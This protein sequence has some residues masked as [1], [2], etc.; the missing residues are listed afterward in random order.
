LNASDQLSLVGI[1]HQW[2]KPEVIKTRTGKIELVYRLVQTPAELTAMRD[3]LVK[4]THI[5]YDSE[6]SG[7]FVHLGARII[8]HALACYTG[9]TQITAWYIPIRHIGVDNEE[10]PQLPVELVSEAVAAILAAPGWCG[11]F[12]AKFDWAQL[13]ADGIPFKRTF[14]DVA[15]LATADNEN[16]PTFALKNLAAKYCDKEARAEQK[17]MDEWMR[18]D[19]RKLGLPYKKR[20]RE[21]DGVLGEAS[22]MDRFGFARSPINLCGKYACKD[23]FYTIYL[24]L[25]RYKSVS[26]QW[27]AVVAREN[28]VSKILHEMEWN[29]LP[30]NAALIRDTHDRTEVEYNYW[31]AEARRL[32]GNPEFAGTDAELRTLFYGKLAMRVPKETK[33]G[34]QAS[35]D[36]EARLLLAKQ[37]PA[38]GELLDTLGNL[39]RA[40]KLFTTYTANFLRYVSPTTGRIHA[41]YNQLE[42]RE[43][44]GPPVTGR[45][46]S[47]DPNMQNIDS[48][49]ME[50][51]DGS[52][53]EIRRYFTVPEGYIRFYIDFSQIELR[54]LTWYCQDPV[55][56]ECYRMGLDVHQIIADQLGI[57][58]KIAKQVN[59][60]NSYGM[61][62]IGLALR[63]PGYYD[64]PV[65]TREYAK[66]VLA[67]YFEKYRNIRLFKVAAAQQMRENGNLFVSPFGRPRRIALLSAEEQW[68]RERGERQMMSSIV[69]GTAADLMKESMIRCDGILQE[70]ELGYGVRGDAGA[71]QV[72][73]IHDE[74]VFD[75]PNE[76]GWAALLVKLAR[77]ME[78]WPMFSAPEGREGVPI[79]V[80]ADIS[81]TTWADKRA[82]E[83]LPDDTLRWAA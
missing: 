36:K 63:I 42:R 28:K 69:S 20:R 6:T 61:T 1:E 34:K 25:V 79:Q 3:Q 23:V 35:V 31:L 46:S 30:A 37:Y 49:P 16:E 67:A 18:V 60:G 66:K 75:V 54:V 17:E 32:T 68:L 77:T 40:H 39:A 78:D 22:Y 15:T 55:L 51:R 73:T 71:K 59:F 62:E 5:V 33:K 24:A 64:D 38:H 76:P 74:L 45:L 27:A 7:L 14:E 19:A 57:L 8:G 80:S 70:H 52:T 72:Q 41:S 26:T 58:R 44:G 4:T 83:I 9:P 65:G 48:R 21:V 13:R 56:L 12:H 82:V 43:K 81:T 47:A 53:V 29:G 2:P 50:L 11:F 10:A